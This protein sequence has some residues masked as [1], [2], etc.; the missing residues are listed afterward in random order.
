MVTARKDERHHISQR[1]QLDRPR[2]E[3]LSEPGAALRRVRP[4]GRMSLADV[5]VNAQADAQW[6]AWFAPG[7]IHEA[8][9][10][11]SGSDQ[12]EAAKKAVGM[13]S[14]TG[15]RV[16][17]L[18]SLRSAQATITTYDRKRMPHAYAP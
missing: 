16:Y 14:A 3:R 17:P 15:D 13:R 12:R 2:A 11:P 5:M 7:R 9:C 1:A 18:T 6:S 10:T 8:A 4:S